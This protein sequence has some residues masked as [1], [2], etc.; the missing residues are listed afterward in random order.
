MEMFVTKTAEWAS[1]LGIL[2][3]IFTLIKVLSLEKFY[4]RKARLPKQITVLQSMRSELAQLL[5]DYSKNEDQI[6][7]VIITIK[8]ILDSLSKKV[9]GGN[10]KKIEKCTRDINASAMTIENTRA[11]YTKL[12]EILA[13]LNE[14]MSDNEW[15]TNQ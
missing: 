1:I 6:R 8:S 5:S 15:R 4:I 9:S 12:I 10:R 7:E 2:I 14:Y 13:D 3:T 11:L